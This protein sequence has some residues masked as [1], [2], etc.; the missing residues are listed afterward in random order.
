MNM[1]YIHEYL[2]L[3]T[4]YENLDYL[5]YDDKI[6]QSILCTYMYN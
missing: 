5:F 6:K 1:S 3:T 2:S 4:Y